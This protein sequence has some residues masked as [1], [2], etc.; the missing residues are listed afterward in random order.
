MASVWSSCH[1][2]CLTRRLRLAFDVLRGTEKTSIVI[3]I[4]PLVAL[5]K[6]QVST[7]RSKGLSSAFIS[8]ESPRE[9]KLGV[10]S[11]DY[12]L[13]YFSPESILSN[14]KWRDLLRQEPY[15][16]QTVALV[17]DEAHCVKKW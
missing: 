9:V 16:S 2:W 1:S 14:R 7:F 12:Q 17:V 8:S 5:M 6:D 15:A 4:S 13:V 10:L 11:G 3:V